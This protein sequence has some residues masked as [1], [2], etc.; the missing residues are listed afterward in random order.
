MN[1]CRNTVVSGHGLWH[2]VSDGNLQ[3][4]HDMI[5]QAFLS[6]DMMRIAVL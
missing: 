2:M 5:L 4:H 6:V 3:G 1:E